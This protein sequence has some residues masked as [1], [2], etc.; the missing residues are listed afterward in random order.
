MEML[1][2]KF[3]KAKYVNELRFEKGIRQRYYSLFGT[4]NT[5]KIHT[6]L[7]RQTT[8]F[9]EQSLYTTLQN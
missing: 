4:L 7:K 8:F 3:S 2:T 1:V 6:S 5:D 9:Y